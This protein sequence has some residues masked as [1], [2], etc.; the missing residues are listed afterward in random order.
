MTVFDRLKVALEAARAEQDLP[1]VLAQKI[2]FIIENPKDFRHRESELT[3]L[4]EQVTLYDTYGQ[5]GYLGMG[6]NNAILDKTL[7]KFV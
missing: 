3:I 4:V 6:V 2:V 1:D 5:T 7:K